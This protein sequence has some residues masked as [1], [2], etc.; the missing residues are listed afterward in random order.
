[1]TLMQM[2]ST[3]VMSMRT[4]NRQPLRMLDIFASWAFSAEAL[5]PLVPCQPSIP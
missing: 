3:M 4:L 1:M 5:Y 2:G